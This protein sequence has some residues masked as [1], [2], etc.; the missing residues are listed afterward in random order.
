MTNDTPT[1]GDQ[2]PRPRIPPQL[3]TSELK[4]PLIITVDQIFDS[5]AINDP[6]ELRKVM[7]EVTASQPPPDAAGPA[8]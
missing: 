6:D 7:A 2:P 5:D 3:D 8:G 1:P 4:F